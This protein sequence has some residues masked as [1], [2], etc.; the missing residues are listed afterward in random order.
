MVKMLPVLAGAAMLAASVTAASADELR[1]S[2]QEMDQVTAGF[3]GAY[4]DAF[5]GA[6]AD[7]FGV[8]FSDANTWTYA[9]SGTFSIPFFVSSAYATSYSASESSSF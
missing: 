1:L 4:A 8:F 7:A 9:E 3:F 5:A 6:E 2:E